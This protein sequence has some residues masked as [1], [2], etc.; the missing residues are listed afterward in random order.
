M[1]RGT[2][3]LDC[4]R[5]IVRHT[6]QLTCD[7]FSD[8]AV[9]ICTRIVLIFRRFVAHPDPTVM[10]GAEVSS[11][12]YSD[13]QNLLLRYNAQLDLFLLATRHV[14]SN[15]RKFKVCIFQPTTAKE[16][17]LN[18]TILC[19]NLRQAVVEGWDVYTYIVKPIIDV[20]GP[21]R[22]YGAYTSFNLMQ[23]MSKSRTWYGVPF[24]CA[25]TRNTDKL[26]LKLLA[27]LFRYA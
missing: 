24:L 23:A 14:L 9:I 6:I 4:V 20:G 11:Y 17:S 22:P 13:A 16:V 8:V 18:P 7:N 27:F 26:Y 1:W 5:V 25:L 12:S 3:A 15:S 21:I 2:S 19:S 10:P